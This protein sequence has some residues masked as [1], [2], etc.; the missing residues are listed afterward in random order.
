MNDLK[1]PSSNTTAPSKL[2]LLLFALISLFLSG[3]VILFLAFEDQIKQGANFYYCLLIWLGAITMCSIA[4]NKWSCSR[5]LFPPIDVLEPPIY[6]SLIWLIWIAPWILA[7]FFDSTYLIYGMRSPDYLPS[8]MFLI[9]VGLLSMWL[10]YGFVGKLWIPYKGTF[11]NGLKQP[12]IGITSIVYVCLLLI[13]FYLTSIGLGETFNRTDNLGVWEQWVTYLVE[14]RWILIASIVL[15]A[16]QSKKAL[17]TLLCVFVAELAMAL[18]SGW[19]N[20]LVKFVLVL[21]GCSIYGNGRVPVRLIAIIAVL[22]LFAAPSIRSIRGIYSDSRIATVTQNSS[23]QTALS[24]AASYLAERQSRVAQTP[25]LIMSLTP[26]VV[27]YRQPEELLLSPLFIVPRAVWL[28]KPSHVDLQEALMT[29]YMGLAFYTSPAVTEF[30]SLYMYGG[31]LVV[32]IGMFLLGGVASLFYRLLIVQ[33]KYSSSFQA[34]AVVYTMVI[35]NT[36]GYGGAE[37]LSMPQRFI[38]SLVVGLLFI[39]LLSLP[40]LL[41]RH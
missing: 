13:R 28:S 34:V 27:P 15:Y 6:F 12:S 7:P 41:K 33:H 10:G 20:P 30:G 38:Q 1:V 37:V 21:I 9:F 8:G 2:P 29:M 17:L 31:W 40:K 25:A 19:V 14:M 24:D 36:F 23:F 4:T 16:T 11:L 32:I 22:I 3:T 18:A 35:V 39:Y 5:V 26:D